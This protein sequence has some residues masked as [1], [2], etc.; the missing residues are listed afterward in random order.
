MFARPAGCLP[1]ARSVARSRRAARPPACWSAR[2]PAAPARQPRG[3]RK[4][5]GGTNRPT[6][7]PTA[8]RRPVVRIPGRGPPPQGAPRVAKILRERERSGPGESIAHFLLHLGDTL[9]LET[10]GAP[11][12][13]GGE[14][15]RAMLIDHHLEARAELFLHV[16]VETPAPEEAI[17]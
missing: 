8:R 13:P 1:R 9:E 6:P 14:A 16:V 5:G 7:G 11:R 2:R 17:P 3:C 4:T 12:F 15:A 10:R